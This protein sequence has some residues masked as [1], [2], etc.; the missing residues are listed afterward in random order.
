[1]QELRKQL[2]SYKVPRAY[3]QITRDEV[4]LL[5]SNKV[6]RRDV[7]ALVAQRLGRPAA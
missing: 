4:P 5:H 7:T 1:M 3:V 6:S 2:S